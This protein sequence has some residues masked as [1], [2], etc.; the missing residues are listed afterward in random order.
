MLTNRQIDRVLGKLKRFETTLEPMLFEPITSLDAQMYETEQ[1][2]DSAPV[3]AAYIP[4]KKG[5]VW[6]GEWKYCWFQTEYTVP[7]EYANI[8]L[9]LKA[10]VGGQESMLFIDGVPSGIFTIPQNGA[11]HGYHYCDLITMGTAANT[12]YHFDLEA[13]AWH[14]TPGSQPMVTNPM[15]DFLHHYNSIEVCVK[16]PV[17]NQFYFDLKTFDQMTEVLDANSFVR[18]EIIKTLMRVHEIVYYSPDDTDKETFLAAIKEAQKELTK[19]Y[20]YKNTSLAPVAN[21]VGHSHMDTAWHWPIDQT[22]KKCARTFSNQLK[23]MEE[24]PE[25]RFIQSSSYHSYMMKVHYPSLYEGMKKAIASGRYEPNG[26]VWVECD[27]NIP[28]GEWMVRQFVWGQLYTQKEF[29]YLSDCFWLPDT[30]G[31]SAALPQIMKSCRVDYFLTTKISWH[32]TNPFPYDTFLWKGIDGTQVLSH[33]NRNHLWPDPQTLTDAVMDGHNSGDTIH[34]KTVTNKRLLSYGFGDGGGGPTRDD[35]EYAKREQ[36]LEGAP[37]VELSDP[38]NFF[39]KM[40]EAGGPVNT[41]VGELYFNAHRGTYTSQ[42]KVKQNNRRAE[43]ALREMEMWGAFGLCKGN[44]YDSEKADAL[45]K[46]LLLNQFH[47]ILP[48]SSMGRVYEEARKA[49]GGVIE[50]AN[51]QAD[52]YMSQLVTKENE[53]DVTLFNSFGFERKTVVELPEAFADGAKTFEGEEVFVEKT[54]F[55]VKAWVTIPPCG[56]VTLVPYKKKN[57]E[58][59]AVSA[60]KTTDGIALENSQVRVKINKKG[61]V[62]SFVL[63]ESG[64]EFAADALNCFHFYKDVPRM[65]D[66]WDI[67]SNYREQELEGAFDVCTELVADGIE[68]VIKVTGKIGKSSYTQ[69]IRLAKDSRR[70]EFDT[71][72]DWK[73]LHRLLKTSFPVAVYAENGINEM[74]FG[75]VMRPTHRSREYEKDRFE[76]CNHRYSALCDASHGAAVLNDCKYGISMNQNALELTLLRAAAAPEM[77][78][79]NQV[80][81]FTYAFTAWEGDFA[82]CDVVKQG[83]ELNEKPRL[84]LGCVP[85]FSMASV[86]SGTVVLDTIKPA[87]DRSGDLI[88]RL[89]ES[90]K[91]AGKAQILLNVDAKKAWLCDMLENKEQEIVIKDGMLELEFG[92]FQIQ[93]IRLSIEE[94]MA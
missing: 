27:C 36:N 12:H 92:A 84:V 91:A 10:D 90:K 51:K 89:Y 81:H 63:K 82:G 30:F 14:Y 19:L 8:P 57:V 72:I 46:E 33:F 43:F 67:D 77:R 21:L 64:R 85:T 35:I 55:G 5:A 34:E 54:P 65:F 59:K 53:N 17:I 25:Y 20:Q 24:Y 39:K 16:N 68:A 11:A 23:L 60:E 2:L 4:A 40:D 80:H 13:Y 94:A 31:Y 6:G 22:I 88:L 7:E 49:V 38:K 75:Y 50:T 86:K 61:E 87:L 18:A 52:I 26:A 76:V 37:R 78:A 48:G 73:E 42:A 69:Y 83:Y 41:Y 66:A 62:T 70:L 47:D 1:N 28:G 79:D 74:Q 93:T 29:G 44:V 71:T 56:A 45:W 9:F 58:Q 3:D 15:P 32:D